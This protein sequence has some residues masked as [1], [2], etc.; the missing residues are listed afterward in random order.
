VIAGGGLKLAGALSSGGDR[1]VIDGWLVHGSA[2]VVG[3]LSDRLRSLQTGFL[4]HYAFA[5]IIGL[6]ALVFAFVLIGG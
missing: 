3:A 5:M 2:R 1:T 6:V 4:Y